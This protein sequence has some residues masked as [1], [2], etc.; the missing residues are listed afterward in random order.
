[1]WWKE[2][3]EEIRCMSVGDVN[4]DGRSEIV[5]GMD[6]DRIEVY[7]GDGELLGA[8]RVA[9]GVEKVQVGEIVTGEPARIVCADG[10]GR[11][12]L[13]RFGERP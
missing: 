11:V 13:F 8:E 3:G 12:L 9:G 2:I 4:G 6:G 7:D 10:T 5:V 1:M